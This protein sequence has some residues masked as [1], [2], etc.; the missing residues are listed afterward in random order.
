M[1]GILGT[2]GAEL[3]L[4]FTQCGAYW[5]TVDFWAGT[6]LIFVMAAVQIIYFS[7]VFGLERGWKEIHSGAAIQIPPVFKIVM[8][9]IAPAYLIIVFVGFCIQNLGP[10]LKAAWANTGSRAA[11]LSILATLIFLLIVV[12][13]GERR[14]RAQGLDIDDRQPAD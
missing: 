14:W 1:I 7:W 12:R 3:T 6:L 2:I 11:V 4:W 5:S 13:M 10:S 9:Y 8:K